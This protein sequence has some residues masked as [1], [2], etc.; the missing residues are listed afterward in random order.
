MKQLASSRS[1]IHNPEINEKKG[2]NNL[3]QSNNVGTML[4][5]DK[6]LNSDDLLSGKE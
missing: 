6:T 1:R 5:N 3:N 4:Q 2:L